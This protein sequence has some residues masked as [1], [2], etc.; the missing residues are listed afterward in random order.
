[1]SQ[2]SK[3]SA[4]KSQMV[5]S[6]KIA[7]AALLAIALAGELGLKYSATAGIITVLSIQN[8]KRETLK[9][10]GKRGLAFLCAIALSAVCFRLFDFTLWAFAIYLFFFAFLCLVLGW[11]EAIA[12]DS[13]LIT[14][15]LTEKSMS[16]AMLANESLL[17]LIGAGV[18]ILVNL[19]LH[20]KDGAFARLA[21]EADN[22]IKG[23]LHR[24]VGW[25]P[26][27]DKTA[28]G[29]DCFERLGA[30]LEEAKLCA[31]ANYNN[32]LFGKSSY[33][34]DYIRMRERQSVLLKEIY[35]NIKRIEYLPK[36]A[37][38]VAVLLG[39]IEAGYHRDNTVEELLQELETLLGE[40]KEQ[41]LPESREEFEARA[42]LFYI[43]MQL[44]NLLYLKREFVEQRESSR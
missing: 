9:S 44:K 22:Q 39:K 6:L 10:A 29:G 15:F 14:H 11:G 13:V 17:F 40:M 1:M 36:Q 24:M 2:S 8:T 35:N 12:M 4:W 33:E 37:E 31:A 38:Q 7:V 43:L 27:E 28:Y 16:P 32:V 20:K 42:I 25:L 23:I 21:E 30:A 26:R 3:K 34:L 19:H 18:G 41:P 5:K